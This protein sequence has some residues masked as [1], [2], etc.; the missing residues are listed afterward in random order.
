VRYVDFRGRILKEL[1]RRRTGLTY[2]ELRTRLDLPYVSP[3]PE[4][5]RRM[6]DDDGLV[7]ASVEGGGRALVWS[8]GERRR[9]NSKKKR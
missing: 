2:K 7:R 6:E 3:C 9:K 8:L 5:V 4:W 1:R